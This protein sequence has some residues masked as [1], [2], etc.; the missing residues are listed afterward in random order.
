MWNIFKS[1]AQKEKEASEKLAKQEAENKAKIE[2]ERLKEE[3]IESLKKEYQDVSERFKKE[4]ESKNDNIIETRKWSVERT[5]STCPKCG[6]KKLIDKVSR[7]KGE[8]DGES[9]SSFS[10]NS[11][12]SIF[13]HY[14]SSRFDSESSLHGEIDTLSVNKC[15]ECGNEWK[16]EE[17]KY[18]RPYDMEDYFEP[19]Y[20]SLKE[21]YDAKNVSFD[22][23]DLSEKFNSKEE[24][25][26]HMLDIANKSIWLEESKK[27]WSGVHTEVFNEILKNT[28][29]WHKEY[30]RNYIKEYNYKE[31]MS[32]FVNKIGMIE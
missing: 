23:S 14:S 17:M 16:K 9:S 2:K 30:A 31:K 7:I 12:S 22:S 11:S 1:K 15:A 32:I 25:T 5:N 8:I 28:I 6:S 19:I 18:S 4:I 27:Y 24:K 29:F 26:Q 10:S 21:F 3:K 20:Y 13:S